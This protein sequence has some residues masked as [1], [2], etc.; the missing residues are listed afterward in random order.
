MSRTYSNCKKKIKKYLGGNF[1]I[2]LPIINK[3]QIKIHKED[4]NNSD[5]AYQMDISRKRKGTS[6]TIH[7]QNIIL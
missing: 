7:Q 5:H 6:Q 2:Y 4:L 1:N 3:I